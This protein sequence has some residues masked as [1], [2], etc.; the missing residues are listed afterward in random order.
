M[1]IEVFDPCQADYYPG[2][3]YPPR[4]NTA[5]L[6]ADRAVILAEAVKSGD[7]N[8]IREAIKG[9]VALAE[10]WGETGRGC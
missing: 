4:R 1:R 7:E 8:K 9:V 5:A 3:P 2:W 6:V 10:I